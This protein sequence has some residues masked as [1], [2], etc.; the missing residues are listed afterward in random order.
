M[1][2]YTPKIIEDCILVLGRDTHHDGHLSELGGA[3]LYTLPLPLPEVMP[4][5]PLVLFIPNMIEL[6]LNEGF[7][8]LPLSY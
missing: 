3:L 1:T 7:E 2:I 6:G 4:R 5:D 8:I